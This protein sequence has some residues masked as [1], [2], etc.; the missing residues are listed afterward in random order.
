MLDPGV[1]PQCGSYVAAAEGDDVK[2]RR[3]GP[4]SG[5]PYGRFGHGLLGRGRRAKMVSYTLDR[6]LTI[7]GVIARFHLAARRQHSQG[8]R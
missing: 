3:R 6:L 5:D 7:P 8:G 4:E 1:A 2:S